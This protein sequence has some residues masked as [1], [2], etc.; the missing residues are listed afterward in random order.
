MLPSP[1]VRHSSFLLGGSTRKHPSSSA[2]T[3]TSL[4]CQAPSTALLS[5][6]RLPDSIGTFVGTANVELLVFVFIA[7][8]LDASIGLLRS[9]NPSVLKGTFLLHVVLIQKQGSRG[10]EFGMVSSSRFESW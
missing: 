9:D 10:K 7:V 2:M 3:K 8:N 4:S 5:I 6:Y 1:I